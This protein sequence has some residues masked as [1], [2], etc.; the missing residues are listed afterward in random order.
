MAALTTRELVLT[1]NGIDRSVEVATA[2]IEAGAADA[3]KVTFAQAR[4]GGT[5]EYKLNLGFVQDLSPGSLWREIWDN[6][7]DT[8]PFVLKGY[9]SGAATANAPWMQGNCVITEPDGPIF[10][11]DADENVSAKFWTE[12][13]WVCTEK[14]VLVGA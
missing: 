13:S 6:A 5:R 1:I 7:G 2:E 10:G 14:P 3:G 11:G 4:S 12:V 9:G 8:V